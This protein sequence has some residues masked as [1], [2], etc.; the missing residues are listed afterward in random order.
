MASCQFAAASARNIRS[1]RAGDQ[2][3]LKVEGV[4]DGGVH[5]QKALADPADL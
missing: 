3:A 1:V 4:V 2:M 5:A